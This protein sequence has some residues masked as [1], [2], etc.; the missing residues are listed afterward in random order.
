MEHLF[1]IK[2]ALDAGEI[3]SMPADRAYDGEKIQTCDFLGGKA[4]FPTGSFALATHFNVPVL[5][6]FAM[7]ENMH[8]YHIYVHRLPDTADSTDKQQRIQFLTQ[9]YVADIENI[10]KMYPEQWFN[11]YQF[12]K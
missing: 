12:W 5:T 9:A 4:D 7:K 10:L 6:V 2:N 8:R 1:A 3:V 11:Y